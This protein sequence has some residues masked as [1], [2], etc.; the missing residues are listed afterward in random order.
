MQGIHMLETIIRTRRSVKPESYTGDPV[1]DDL[2]AALLENAQ[3]APTHA[4]TE[5]WRFVVCSGNGL[6]QLAEFQAELYKSTTTPETFN[7]LKYE[8]LLSGPLKASH[9]IL[10]GMKRQP[11]QK[12]P[13][14]E[15]VAAVSCAVQNILLSAHAYGIGAYWSTGGMTYHPEMRNFMQLEEHDQCLG[16]IYIGNYTLP[17]AEGKRSGMEDKVI[18]LR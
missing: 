7:Q 14:V 9:I 10:I 16:M 5:P 3:W 18:W 8:K 1:S 17:I 2:I 13:E 4:R 11:T 12:L 15:E 6:Q